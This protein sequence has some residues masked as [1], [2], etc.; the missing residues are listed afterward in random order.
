MIRLYK[1][2]YLPPFLGGEDNKAIFGDHETT[3]TIYAVSSMLVSVSQQFIGCYFSANVLYATRQE[4]RK[5]GTEVEREREREVERGGERWR[6]VE[7]DAHTHRQ[8]DRHTDTHTDR[9][10]R[11]QA[12]TLT[13]S[14]THST[15]NALSLLSACLCVQS[16]LAY[17]LHNTIVSFFVPETRAMYVHHVVTLSLILG[18]AYE[19]ATCFGSVIL[20][21]HNVPDVFIAMAKGCVRVRVR[22][23]E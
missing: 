19:G 3:R 10:A 11:R 18:S 21:L 20:F 12:D 16:G 6:E 8:M 13:H 17:H 1:Q 7:R 15:I 22:E 5:G 23:R 2:P 4:G 9:H 14:L